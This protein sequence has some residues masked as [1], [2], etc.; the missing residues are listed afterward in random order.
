MCL[1][2]RKWVSRFKLMCRQREAKLKKDTKLLF[3]SSADKDSVFTANLADYA[4]LIAPDMK[5]I[6]QD[7]SKLEF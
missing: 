1:I 5:E 6:N 3:V 2:S 4:D 7:L